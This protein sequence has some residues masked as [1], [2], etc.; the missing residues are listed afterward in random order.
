MHLVFNIILLGFALIA[1]FWCDVFMVVVVP[2]EIILLASFAVHLFQILM[3]FLQIWIVF[4]E[5]EILIFS[6]VGN[7][8]S[9]ADSFESQD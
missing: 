2:L 3:I 5:F 1:L 4:A 7:L 8:S 6:G 9:I